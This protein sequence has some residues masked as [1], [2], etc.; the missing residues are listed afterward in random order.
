MYRR[1]L[2]YCYILRVRDKRYLIREAC[3]HR[4]PVKHGRK[5]MF[6]AKKFVATRANFK[7]LLK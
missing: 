2:F 5:T 3:N 4:T 6:V 1:A 7:K